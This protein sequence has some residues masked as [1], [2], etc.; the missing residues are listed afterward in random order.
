[1]SKS[2][3]KLVDETKEQG[4]TELDLCDRSLNTISDIP[5]LSKCISDSRKQKRVLHF[6]EVVFK[7]VSNLI[8]F[9]LF[10]FSPTQAFGASNY[11][12]QPNN[13]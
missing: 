9:V 1:M 5:G 2:I 13:M 3:K 10:L 12:S 11:K 7:A 4:Y 8:V 6:L